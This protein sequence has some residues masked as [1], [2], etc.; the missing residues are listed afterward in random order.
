MLDFY[1][2][3]DEQ[4]KPNYPEQVN[5]EFITGLDSGTFDNLIRKGIIDSRF[6]YYSD[7]RW[8]S[9]L[10]EQINSKVSKIKNS[11]S[12]IDKLNLIIKKALELKCG[13]IAYCD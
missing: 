12:D 7:F 5:L 1:I 2:I 8:D 3:K 4:P 11:D 13:I 10:I 6:D 9:Y